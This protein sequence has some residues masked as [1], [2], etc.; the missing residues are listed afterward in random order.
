MS[1]YSGHVYVPGGTVTEPEID[2]K[3]LFKI[4]PYRTAVISPDLTIL[5]VNDEYLTASGRK[6]EDLLGHSPFDLFPELLDD[7]ADT[8]PGD[9]RAS[10]EAVLAS[11]ERDVVSLTRY[12]VEDPGRPGV[13]EERYWNVVSTPMLTDTGRVMMIVVISHDVTPIVSQLRA[14]RDQQ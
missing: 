14:E 5:D 2:Y 1:G 3:R 7:P 11:G 8:G 10:L 13:F 9:L 12:D 4:G 6:R